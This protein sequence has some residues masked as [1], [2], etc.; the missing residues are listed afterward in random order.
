MY[1]VGHDKYH[2]N[3][4]LFYHLDFKQLQHLSKGEFEKKVAIN[5]LIRL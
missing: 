2:N 1:K 3:N 5:G 4:I